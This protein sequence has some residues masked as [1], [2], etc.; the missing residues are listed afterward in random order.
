M[1][2]AMSVSGNGREDNGKVKDVT[3]RLGA[4]CIWKQRNLHQV[5]TICQESFVSPTRPPPSISRSYHPSHSWTFGYFFQPVTA[6]SIASVANNWI[7]LGR[8]ND[9]LTAISGS[10]L[11]VDYSRQVLTNLKIYIKH[12][13]SHMNTQQHSHTRRY[14]WD[15]FK[16]KQAKI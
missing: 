9:A 5:S 13:H 3:F 10:Q 2:A 4:E 6:D 12:T 14:N 15:H 11:P 8:W 7:P 1:M 16:L